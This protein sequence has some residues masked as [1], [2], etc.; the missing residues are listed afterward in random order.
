MAMDVPDLFQTLITQF[1]VWPEAD[2]DAYQ[3]AANSLGSYADLTLDDTWAANQ[4]VQRLLSTGSGEAMDALGQH[5]NKVKDQHAAAITAAAQV[6]GAAAAAIATDIAAAKINIVQIAAS[7]A[8]TTVAATAAGPLTFGASEAVVGSAT[9]QCRAQAQAVVSRCLE[10]TLQTLARLEKDPSVAALESAAADLGAGVGGQ[11][12]GAAG[13]V[14]GGS[15]TGRGWAHGLPSDTGRAIAGGVH[16]DHAEHRLAAGKLREV[17][18]AV[19]GTTV[20]ALS[21]AVGHHATATASGSLGA[22]LAPVLDSVLDRLSK[23]NTA[24]GD[25]L[26]GALPDGILLI[27][28]SQQATDDDNRQRMS[29]LDR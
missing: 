14:A 6:S 22:A 16:V 5:W 20:A 1:L 11:A 2:E 7:L 18:A 29:Q 3:S 9:V 25:H 13:G 21:Q 15:G 26:D 27:S 28:T 8:E 24:F 12:G 4:H 17:A 19:L 23:A 10:H